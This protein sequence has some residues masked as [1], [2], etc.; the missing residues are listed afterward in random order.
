MAIVKAM[1]M[2]HR[3]IAV[4]TLTRQGVKTAFKIKDVLGKMKLRC[5][6]F[7][8][9]KY[10]QK[11]IVP[12]DKKLREFVKDI[13]GKVDAIVAVMT[14]GI[15]VRTIAP[16]LKSKM[17]DPAIVCVDDS[18]RFVI[19]LL[20][21]HYGGA[22]ELT[23][24]IANG[25]GAMPVITTASEVMGKKSV[26]EL[27]RNL[28][29][30]IKNPESLTAVNSA[31][32]N[33]ERLVMVLTG[34][35]KVL[36]NKISDYEIKMAKNAERA[37]EIVKDF[38]AGIIITKEEILQNELKKPAI[39]LKPQK[40]TIGIGSRKDVSENEVIEAVDFALTQV[41]IPLERVDCLATI[42]VKKDS[43]SIVNAAK[44][45]GLNL[46]FVSINALRS[47]KHPDLSPDSKLVEQKIGVGGVCERVALMVAGKKAKLILK[48]MKVKGV[49]VA[50]A[51]GE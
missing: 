3:S 40:I 8:P 31:I 33:G 32:V 36:M 19:S 38:D 46:D 6:I 21:G 41:N 1:M 27:A 35:V 34:D 14:T 42:D 50:I 48:K 49:T 10:A 30:E 23:R 12:L 43:S 17:S 4:L 2:F 28:H 9:K 44:R 5:T 25:I 37:M 22:N 18:G 13:F 39:I 29:C 16:C 26:E 45:L 11:G 15:I 47:F 20:S 51:E 7:A 24:L